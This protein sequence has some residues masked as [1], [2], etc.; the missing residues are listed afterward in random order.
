MSDIWFVSDTHFNHENILKF[1]DK[2]GKLVRGAIFSNIQEM[3]ECI[4]DN[5]NEVVK[6]GDKVYHLG[7]VFFGS[8]SEFKEFWPTLNGRKNLIVGNHDDIKW[9]SKGNFFRKVYMWRCFKDEKFFASHVPMNLD[10]FPG[11]SLVN[12]HGHIHHRKGPGLHHFNVSLEAN[13]YY[14][15]NMEDIKSYINAC[16][17]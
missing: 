17:S 5:W 13:D 10:N 12:V 3:N 14:P 9:L 11:K 7:D 15:V 4:R 2:N 1:T 16:F 6:P 8:K